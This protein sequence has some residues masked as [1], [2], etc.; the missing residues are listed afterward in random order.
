MIARAF[1]LIAIS[2]VFLVATAVPAPGGHGESTSQCNGGAV[3]C[4]NQVQQASSINKIQA[5]LLAIMGVDVNNLT[6][7]VGSNC[8]P[9]NV[10]AGGTGGS[11]SDSVGQQVCCQNNYYNGLI[12]V[13][14]SPIG[15]AL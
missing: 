12:N 4:C 5:G 3:S 8:S 15:I 1:A 13:G 6:G 11:W 14:C 7:Q 2:S 9:V 10:L